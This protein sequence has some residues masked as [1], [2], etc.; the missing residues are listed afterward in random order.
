MCKCSKQVLLNFDDGSHL[1]QHRKVLT[2][3]EINIEYTHN[4]ESCDAID[5][6]AFQ[7]MRFTV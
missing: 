5:R 7:E 3:T 1:Q 4:E 2:M 6:H